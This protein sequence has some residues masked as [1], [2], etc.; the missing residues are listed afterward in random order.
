MCFFVQFFMMSSGISSRDAEG[1]CPIA[2]E[3]AANFVAHLRERGSSRF[4]R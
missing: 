1:T 2:D 4:L 3:R